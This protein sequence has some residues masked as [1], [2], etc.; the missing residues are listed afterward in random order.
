M[1]DCSPRVYLECLCLLDCGAKGE[2]EAG[3]RNTRRDEARLALA[4]SRSLPLSLFKLLGVAAT[5]LDLQSPAFSPETRHRRAPRHTRLSQPPLEHSLISQPPPRSTLLHHH[6]R[7]QAP[8]A[9]AG[10]P[11]STTNTPP[12]PSLPPSRARKPPSASPSPLRPRASPSLQASATRPAPSP[13]APAPRSHPAPT[14]RRRRR[15]RTRARL[16]PS[17]APRRAASSRR[18]MAAP[19]ANPR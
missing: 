8:W 18:V 7:A 1:C 14:P 17:R 11:S 16:S 15:T 6:H 9:T 5:R 4:L 19:L 2:G 10:A 12:S 3:R 13:T